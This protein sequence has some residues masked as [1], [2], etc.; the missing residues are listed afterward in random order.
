M[1][2]P[3]VKLWATW[4]LAERP[5]AKSALPPSNTK[6]VKDTPTNT[7]SAPFNPVF[8]CIL[9]R[10]SRCKFSY[11]PAEGKFKFFFHS[12]IRLSNSI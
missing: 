5:L 9:L 3:K 4:K 10:A 7:E 8:H 11:E 6:L 1:P 12:T 2:V